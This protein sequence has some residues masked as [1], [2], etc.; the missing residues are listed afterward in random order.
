MCTLAVS[1]SAFAEEAEAPEMSFLEY[2]GSMVESGEEGVW[3][4][5]LDMDNDVL[6][7]DV[8]Q[9]DAVQPVAQGES[10]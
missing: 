5:P 1:L 6:V 3:L 2:L 7:D 8:E 4:D 10:Q 9:A